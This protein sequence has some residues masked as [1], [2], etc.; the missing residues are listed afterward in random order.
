MAQYDFG[1]GPAV[2]GAA[3]VLFCLWLAWCRFRVVIPLLDKT[4][5]SVWASVDTALRRIG[6]VPPTC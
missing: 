3:T 2:N 1:D 6:G 5:A 4:Q